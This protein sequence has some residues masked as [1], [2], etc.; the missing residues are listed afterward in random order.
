[1]YES[2]GGSESL[3]PETGDRISILKE[4]KKIRVHKSRGVYKKR[5]VNCNLISF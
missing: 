3:S 5:D 2:N 1:M 4:N